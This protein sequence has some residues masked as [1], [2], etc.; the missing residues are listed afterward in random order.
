MIVLF[1]LQLT[2]FGSLFRLGL[3]YLLL[4]ST[5]II[6]RNDSKNLYLSNI[7]SIFGKN[8]FFL[9][10]H[11]GYLLIQNYLKSFND[12][13]ILGCN[14]SFS[15]KTDDL[16]KFKKRGSYRSPFNVL[17]STKP[18]T[19]GYFVNWQLGRINWLCVETTDPVFCRH[20]ADDP[21]PCVNGRCR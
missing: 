15:Y 4:E 16:S 7:F 12:F 3:L 17:N 11:I 10:V 13:G 19:V 20:A 1:L 18:V 21:C 8:L 2:L 9:I 5:Y 6:K 14:I